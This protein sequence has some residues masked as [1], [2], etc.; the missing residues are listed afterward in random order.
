MIKKFAWRRG[1]SGQRGFLLLE[2]AAALAISGILGTTVVGSLHQ[3]QRTTIDGGAQF[4]LTT[5]TQRATRWISR[6][7]HRADSTD[8]SDGGAP[9]TSASFDWTDEFGAHSCSYVLNGDALE[10]ACDG[11]LTVVA[12]Q[13]SGLSFSR[14]G[15]LIL[16]SF[17]VSA[18]ARPDMSESVSMYVSLGRE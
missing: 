17:D 13:L 1:G 10:R 6:D 5:E 18:V 8:V 14:S 15:S 11:G 16:L 2:F 7:V 12:R 3:L 9:V 4:E